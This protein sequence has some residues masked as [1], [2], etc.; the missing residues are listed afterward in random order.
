MT[1]DLPTSPLDFVTGIEYALPVTDFPRSTPGIFSH[2]TKQALTLR[3]LF[4]SNLSIMDINKKEYYLK[5]NIRYSA[6]CQSCKNNWR[7]FLVEVRA[8]T[9]KKAL[10]KLKSYCREGGKVDVGSIRRLY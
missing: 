9:K 10:K 7:F 1:T 6:F 2:S 5:N 4:L 3:Y 8:H